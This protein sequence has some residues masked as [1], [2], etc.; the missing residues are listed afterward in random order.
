MN[1]NIDVTNNDHLFHNWCVRFVLFEYMSHIMVLTPCGSKGNVI[2]L[3]KV[4]R[5]QVKGSLVLHL[6]MLHEVSIDLNVEFCCKS[7]GA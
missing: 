3:P 2:P 4:H 1:A 6:E 7:I 5:L